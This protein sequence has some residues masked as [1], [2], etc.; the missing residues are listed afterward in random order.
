M[1]TETDIEC[2]HT[3]ATLHARGINNIFDVFQSREIIAFSHLN[4]TDF[5]G[6]FKDNFMREKVNKMTSK[7]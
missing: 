1:M 3:K 6:N 7:S 4:T 2:V 5:N